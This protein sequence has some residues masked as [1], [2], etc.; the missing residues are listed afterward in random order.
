MLTLERRVSALGA[1]LAMALICVAGVSRAQATPVDPSLVGT[2][3]V[4]DATQLVVSIDLVPRDS[5]LPPG[6]QKFIASPVFMLEAKESLPESG[7]P[8]PSAVMGTFGFFAHPPARSSPNELVIGT[9]GQEDSSAVVWTCT[10]MP[11]GR[12]GFG[13]KVFLP[14]GSLERIANARQV[15]LRLGSQIFDM[16]PNG[17]ASVR[18]LLAR[19]P[20][21]ATALDRGRPYLQPVT[22]PPIETPAIAEES[23]PPKPTT[24]GEVLVQFVVDT[25]GRADM[26]TFKV[27]MGD[28]RVGSSVKDVLPKWRFAPATACGEKIREYV[29]LPFAF[30]Q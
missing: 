25:T 4:G 21:A 8:M 12:D 18:A 9:D 19:V 3:R 29:Q 14:R 27:L 23:Y 26:S 10:L 11:E 5:V 6:A 2:R 28:S 30:Q 22:E 1:R 20:Y 17:P 15:T 7:A 24:S 16:S 13:G